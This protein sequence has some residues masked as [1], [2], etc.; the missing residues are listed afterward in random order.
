MSSLKNLCKDAFFAVYKAFVSEERLMMRNAMKYWCV[1]DGCVHGQR[2]K[3][4]FNKE[5]EE[6]NDASGGR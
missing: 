5:Q 2:L 3:L 4:I 6:K 1:D